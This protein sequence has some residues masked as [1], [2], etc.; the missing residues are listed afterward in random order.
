LRLKAA[1]ELAETFES[2]V[3]NPGYPA[4]LE[5]TMKT[6]LKVL[7]EGEAHFFSDF[8]IQQVKI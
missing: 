6:F 5:V 7:Q 2:N 3:N 4:F 1:Q 8:N